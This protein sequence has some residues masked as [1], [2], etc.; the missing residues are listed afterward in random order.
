M[1]INYL[2]N[3]KDYIHVTPLYI[4]FML[5]FDLS[6][7]ALSIITFSFFIFF[8]GGGGGGGR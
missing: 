3:E 4:K 7:L 1:S 6:K 8:W 5:T 2:G